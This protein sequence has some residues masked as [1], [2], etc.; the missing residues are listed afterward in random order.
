VRL[1][2]HLQILQLEFF[3]CA[4]ILDRR[5][6]GKS[7]I[8]LKVG[9]HLIFWFELES[10]SQTRLSP[11]RRRAVRLATCPPFDPSGGLLLRLRQL[12]PMLGGD[13]G[14]VTPG[15]GACGDG[16]RG[17]RGVAGQNRGGAPVAGAATAAGLRRGDLPRRR[18][19]PLRVQVVRAPRGAAPR[20]LPPQ[21]R[22]WSD[23]GGSD[24]G[25]AIAHTPPPA[26]AHTPPPAIAHTPPPAIAHTPPPAIAHT[27][28]PAFH[29]RMRRAGV[30]C[31]RARPLPPCLGCT[32]SGPCTP[33]AGSA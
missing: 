26:I 28:P 29:A 32:P 18:L 13:R 25:G 8:A 6:Y 4:A 17:Q 12:L 24:G 9:N 7:F 15:D 1:P 31:G 5:I 3:Y 22:G 27:P 21:S 20:F 30:V 14:C 33:S 23:P 19:L 11:R 16:E 2:P 10:S